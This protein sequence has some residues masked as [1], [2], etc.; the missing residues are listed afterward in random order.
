VT[1]TVLLTGFG[2]FPGAAVNPTTALVRRLARNRRVTAAEVRCVG[3]VFATRYAA[4]DD[5]FA[6]LLAHHRPDAVVMFGL[7]ARR[8]HVSIEMLAR[9]RVSMV[10]PDAGGGAARRAVIE[11]NAARDRRGRAPMRS[12]LAAARGARVDTRL[13]RDAGRYVCN[14][15]Y[16]RALEAAGR[17]GGPRLAVFVH[18]PRLRRDHAR[19]GRRRRT[20]SLADLTRAG[21]AIVRAVIAATHRSAPT[22]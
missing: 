11:T 6:A 3:H 4:V 20:Y 17:P 10:F 22:H 15:V 5:E 8:A 19:P 14:Y 21:E 7:A 12:L 9:N 1:L 2:P 16:W 18:V 13:S